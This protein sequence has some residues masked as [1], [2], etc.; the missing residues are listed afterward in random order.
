MALL[1][2]FLILIFLVVLILRLI[3]FLFLGPSSGRVGAKDSSSHANVEF[4]PYAILGVKRG[5]SKDEIKQ[6]YKQAL[7]QYHP[8]KVSHLGPELQELARRKTLAI[9]KAYAELE[10]KTS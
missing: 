2:R 9:N 4:D 8:D 6:A 10:R 7:S 3:R 5:C 1:V